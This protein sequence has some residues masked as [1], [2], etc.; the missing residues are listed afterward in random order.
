MWKRLLRML[1]CYKMDILMRQ[2]DGIEA[3]L[4]ASRLTSLKAT[5]KVGDD[6]LKF[7]HDGVVLG[8]SKKDY[9]A[10]TILR[11]LNAYGST[12]KIPMVETTTKYYIYMTVSSIMEITQLHD[13][14]GSGNFLVKKLNEDVIPELHQSYVNNDDVEEKKMFTADKR[15]ILTIFSDLVDISMK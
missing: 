8:L 4:Y 9:S 10:A 12:E 2:R 1:G 3:N 15:Q 7:I 13:R 14:Y 11:A 6:H 5:D